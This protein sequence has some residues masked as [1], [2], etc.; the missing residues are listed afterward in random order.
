MPNNI[1]H[2]LSLLACFKHTTAI[3]PINSGLSCL[4]YQVEADGHVYFAKYL[5]SRT[6]AELTMVASE[7]AIAPAVVYHNSQWLITDFI[8]SDNLAFLSTLKTAS[9]HYDKITIATKLLVQCHQLKVP[10]QTLNPANIIKNLVDENNFSSSQQIQ[11]SRITGQILPQVING[12]NEVFCHGDLNFSN[13]VISQNSTAYLVD[14]ECACAAP[15]EFDLAM[16]IAINNLSATDLTEVVTQYKKQNSDAIISMAKID[17]YLL[18]CYFI[19]GLWYLSAYKNQLVIAEPSNV[20]VLA[21]KQ[22]ATQQWQAFDLFSAIQ[23]KNS[24]PHLCTLF[25]L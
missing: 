1:L 24:I 22:L 20:K 11:L 2:S 23:H 19:N 25:N 12:Q 15:I 16:F 21:L 9:S 6:E 18:F 17:D 8:K 4:C 3:T 13:I 10:T 14:Y 7:Q 5:T